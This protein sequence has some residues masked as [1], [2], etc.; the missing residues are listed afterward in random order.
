M[1]R[2]LGLF[3]KLQ[4][5]SEDQLLIIDDILNETRDKQITWIKDFLGL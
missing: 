2:M 5:A 1:M 4:S 3:K